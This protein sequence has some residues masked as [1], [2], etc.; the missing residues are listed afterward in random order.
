MID[1]KPRVDVVCIGYEE[2]N[3]ITKFPS[4]FNMSA[5]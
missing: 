5:C 1:E 2:I 4:E 3:D